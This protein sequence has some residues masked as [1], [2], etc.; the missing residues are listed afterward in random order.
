MHDSVWLNQPGTLI[1]NALKAQNYIMSQ[2]ARD[3]PLGGIRW[4][5]FYE[6][7]GA[8]GSGNDVDIEDFSADGVFHFFIFLLWQS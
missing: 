5:I 4:L 2:F 1:L 8:D 6:V 3:I 7:A